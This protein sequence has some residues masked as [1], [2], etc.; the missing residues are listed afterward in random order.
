MTD[1]EKIEAFNI[2]LKHLIYRE[3]YYCNQANW[4][5]DYYWFSLENSDKWNK[6]EKE[7]F[8]KLRNLLKG[9]KII[10]L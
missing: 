5:N 1:Q 8:M 9:V 4:S 10:K 7:D 3:G 2:I 6:E